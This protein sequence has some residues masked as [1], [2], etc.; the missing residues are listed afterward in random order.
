MERI[1]EDDVA[2]A[3]SDATLRETFGDPATTRPAAL[4]LDPARRLLFSWSLR[5]F[6]DTRPPSAVVQLSRDDTVGGA[7]AKLARHGILAAPLVDE[8]N[9]HFYGYVRAAR[10]HAPESYDDAPSSPRTRRTRLRTHL[11]RETR[12]M[13]IR[14][15]KIDDEPLCPLTHPLAGSSRARI[16]SAR[17]SPASTPR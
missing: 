17:S 11:F 7:M 2:I 4:D 14:T 13:I 5:R 8:P 15:E 6:L 12:A 16:S 1:G 3:S 9:M 10:P